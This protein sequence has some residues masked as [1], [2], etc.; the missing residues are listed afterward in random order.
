VVVIPVCTAGSKGEV[1]MPGQRIVFLR[2]ARPRIVEGVPSADW[3]LDPEGV[4]SAGLLVGKLRVFS[5]R[6][7]ISSPEPKAL[8]TARIVAERLGVAVSI[9]N[10]LAEHQRRSVG[11]V[12]R[13]AVERRIAALFDNPDQVVFGEETADA[14]FARF[15]ATVERCRAQTDRDLLFATHGTI[16][17]I[18]LSRICGFVPMPFWR[19]LGLP[20]AVVLDDRK[21][22]V[23]N[24]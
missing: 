3:T 1:F 15:S 11:F 18:Y 23:L 9:D 20:A 6:E 5:F 16:L 7:V 2:H 17:T 24:P 14:C 10:G 19:S 12:S 21:I 13:E 4:S 22:D 8:E